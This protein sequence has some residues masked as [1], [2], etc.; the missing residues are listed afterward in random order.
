M[1]DAYVRFP[2]IR[3]EQIAFV[4]DNDIWLTERTGGRAYR[5]SA[6]HAPVQSPRISPDGTRIAWTAVHG[7]VKEVCVAPVDG[8]PTTRLT[9]WG[10]A[11]TWVRGWLS[12]DE[13]LVVS[14]RGEAT[15]DRM[16]A[17]AVPVD[18]G[19][20]RRLPYGWA[21][22]LTFGPDGGVLLATTGTL[23][24]A[25]WKRY[26]GGTAPQLWLDRDDSGTFSRL[27]ADLPSGL[28]SPL[29]TTTPR[30]TERIGFVSDHEGSGQL[31]SAT[32]GKRAPT[33]GRLHRHTDHDFYVR[34]ATTDGR[35]V[36]YVAGGELYLLDSLE[37]GSEP[38]QVDV[39]LVGA[40]SALAPRSVKAGANLGDVRPDHTARASVIESRGTVSWLT[41]RDGPVR[42][43]ADSPG[44]R[45]RL[46]VVLGDSDRVAWVT[47]AD[48]D[49]AI[50]I[51]GTGGDEPRV[52]VAAGRVGRVLAM[53]AAP[54]GRRLAI[55]SHDGR[56]LTANV[57]EGQVARAAAVTEI[58]RTDEGDMTGLAFSPDS[59]WLAWSAPGPE[60]LR[61]I[62]MAR[63]G[64]RAAPID[65]TPLRFTDFEPAFTTDGKHLAF[66]SV[67]SLD[68]VYDAF[69]FDLSFPNGCRPHLVPLAAD[70]PSPFDPR[71][72]GRP[73]TEHDD[74]HADQAETPPATTVDVE[75]L[76][77]RVTAVPVAAG[78][79][80]NLRSVRGGLIWLNHP[81]AGELGDDRARLDDDPARA[82]LEHLA[83]DS[84]KV[85][86]LAEAAD[87]AE[88]SGDGRRLVV[89]AKGK[90]LVVPA[91]RK[92]PADDESSTDRVEVDLDRVRIEVDPRS[93][94]RQMYHEAWRL[95]RDHY[96]RADM[97]GVDW[98]AVREKYAGLLQRIA[99]HDDLVDVLWE[100]HGELGSSH[101]YVTPRSDSGDASARQ[102]LLGA[103]LAFTDGAW[104]I[105]RIVPGESSRRRARSPLTAPGVAVAAGDAIVAVDGRPV[106]AVAGP[107]AR[108]V[109][110]ADKPVELTIAPRDGGD[111]RE[112]VVVPLAD[113]FPLRY[114]DWVAGRRS[115]VHDNSDGRIGYL[116]VPDMVSE[117]WA[118]LHRDL[119]TE[120]ALDGLIVDV[121]GNRGGH[122]SQLVVEKLARRIIGWDLARGIGP[123]SYP[124]DA[125]RGP[126]VTVTD[127]Y[128]GSDGDIVTAAIRSLGLGPVVGTRTW[129]GVV[130]IDGRYSLVDGTSVTQPRYS[131]WFEDFGWGVENHGVDPD[132]EVVMTP[133]DRVAGADPQLERALE[134][135]LRDLRR[136]P[137][138]HPPEIPPLE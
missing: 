110:S 93:E 7:G 15:R 40:R 132:V 96:W 59:Q 103:D 114:Q 135:V 75:H 77:E 69:V 91:D 50:V 125:R 79:Y 122:T 64:R 25:W 27:F 62:R 37:T 46:P 11:G 26:R 53:T 4:A 113:E 21:H 137:A 85:Q 48:G 83:L 30:D 78:N 42:A 138:A 63:L 10:Q 56:L 19:P 3:G 71:V 41:H 88:P 74:K 35:Q 112:V 57:P 34:H 5:V 33:S 49:D 116:H 87:A 120:F 12:D 17:H 136:S 130:G 109:G 44:V 31:Y 18:G 128:A 54:D 133:Q 70:T 43:L 61:Q 72:G 106:D 6:D 90:L 131:F 39:R 16:F 60:P 45:R 36:V 1:T 68:P 51:G 89:R 9:Y 123:T 126:M 73:T 52:L 67:R 82:S 95:M 84:G 115:W 134:L 121:R 23:E 66:L 99:T 65:V 119:R 13:V 98:G 20:S 38:Q 32:L 100:M 107:G 55:A 92:I 108:L 105:A 117:G 80:A 24:A 111:R 2:H 86:V 118:E 101:A 124:A 22:D 104:R 47:D 127:M 129:G 29:W 97:G 102:G 76:H 8:G 81:L 58:D 14:T 94:W 28:A